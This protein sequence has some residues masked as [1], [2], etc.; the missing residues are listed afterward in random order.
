MKMF[1]SVLLRSSHSNSGT[2]FFKTE[3]HSRSRRGISIRPAHATSARLFHQRLSCDP[4]AETWLCTEN[5]LSD[6][7]K[8][9]SS[10][11]LWFLVNIVIFPLVLSLVDPSHF[12]HSFDLQFRPSNSY[13]YSS[14]WVSLGKSKSFSW[15][16]SFEPFIY[17]NRI[18]LSSHGPW[19]PVWHFKMHRSSHTHRPISD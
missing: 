13:F 4:A 1:Q 18:L 11:T 8:S 16:G 7:V 14:E 12:W 15:I 9:S 3:S 6:T 17:K 5:K 10:S 2:F 19:H